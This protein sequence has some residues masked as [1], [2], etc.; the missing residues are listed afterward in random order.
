MLLSGSVNFGPA[1]S[2]MPQAQIP[3][4][5]RGFLRR[6]EKK[7]PGFFAA[8]ALN[9]NIWWRLKKEP[10]PNPLPRGKGN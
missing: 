8:V 3:K 10:N 7:Y 6:R 4:C 2:F 9:D 5:K 1:P